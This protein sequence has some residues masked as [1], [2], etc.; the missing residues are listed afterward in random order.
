[1]FIKVKVLQVSHKAAVPK[2]KDEEFQQ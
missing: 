2:T 1:M